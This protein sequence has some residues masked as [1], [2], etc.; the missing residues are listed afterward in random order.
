[1]LHDVGYLYVYTTEDVKKQWMQYINFPS[2]LFEFKS[3]QQMQKLVG[4]YT[5]SLPT[6]VSVIRLPSSVGVHQR[7]TSISYIQACMD[8]NNTCDSLMYTLWKW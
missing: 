6:Y 2:L 7:L 3:N 1:M 4:K 8:V 5:L